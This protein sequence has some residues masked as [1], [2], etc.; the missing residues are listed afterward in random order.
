MLTV[1]NRCLY[2][3]TK[4]FMLQLVQELSAEMNEELSVLPERNELIRSLDER[5]R[6]LRVRFETYRQ[7]YNKVAQVASTK[8][9]LEISKTL[10]GR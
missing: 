3:I 10:T 5:A 9:A 2:L 6:E 1:C 7:N 4:N 8:L